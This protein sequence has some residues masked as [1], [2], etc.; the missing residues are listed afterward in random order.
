MA[1][2][3][4]DVITTNAG[5]VLPGATVQLLNAYGALVTTYTDTALTQNPS[6]TRT[7][8]SNG[9][10]ELYVA[11]GTYTVRQS[12]NGVTKDLS[13]VELYDISTIATTSDG[14]VANKAQASAIGIG[15]SDEDMGTF[16]GS[17]IS[18]NATAKQALQSLET[19]VE[20]ASDSAALKANAT[21]IGV[22]AS[23][24]D[25]GAFTGATIPDNQTA[26]SALQSLE[27]AYEG[28]VSDLA[29]SASGKGAS[30]VKTTRGLT[31]EG[32][33][34]PAT[35]AEAFAG[36]GTTQ[37]MTPAR[38]KDAVEGMAFSD[39]YGLSQ[40]STLNSRFQR[41]YDMKAAGCPNNGT[42]DDYPT[43]A[44][45]Y[46]QAKAAGGGCI[47]LPDGPVRFN[48]PVVLDDK[49]IAIIGAG[50]GATRWFNP[51]KTNS[52]I[53]LIGADIHSVEIA[54][55]QFE[56]LDGLPQTSGAVF[57]FERNGASS[58]GAGCLDVKL[59]HFTTFYAYH[60]ISTG[61]SA[62]GA[63]TPFLDITVQQFM[64][65]D[66]ANQGIYITQAAGF[67]MDQYTISYPDPQGTQPAAGSRCIYLGD[68]VDGFW[69]GKGN[70]LGGETTFDMGSD[71]VSNRRKP[72]QGEV[73]GLSVD[74]GWLSTAR[75]RAMFNCE[76][77]RLLVG[78]LAG[79]G[80]A[81]LLINGSGTAFDTYQGVEMAKF[82][83]GWCANNEGA[84]L[85]LQGKSK[86]V[87]FH[88][89]HFLSNGQASTTGAYNNAYVAPSV[90]DWG[91]FGCVFDVNTWFGTR[92]AGYGLFVD[93]GCDR[94]WL[95]NNSFNAANHY[96][97]GL[98]NGS[99]GATNK[100]IDGNLP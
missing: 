88:G 15:G 40:S 60:G 42:S 36:T 92:K 89:M 77:H 50:A 47:L 1:A 55:I 58:S 23:A 9:L 96:T 51:S 6:T 57:S 14:A 67:K 16:T 17:T 54:H 28:Y 8:D 27:I 33:T 11:D 44:A 87:Y 65:R 39:P 90:T 98:Y 45:L 79:G 32:E 61:F 12:L 46:A 30:L 82:F 37:K 81:G 63:S 21:A 76:F 38:V 72:A 20:S 78:D 3:Y 83:G 53:R 10:I 26:K 80:D 5:T 56:P 85:N 64:L 99:S 22:S 35:Q 97:S 69:I 95:R 68:W 2:K 43:F 13:N 29:S 18:D 59:H 41:V 4:T 48:S 93:S 25:M 71:W 49:R 7:A 31:L 73:A 84:G 24:A 91:F 74:S 66:M 19:A 52:F 86:H 34:A 94:Y 75:L 100:T 70:A 62:Q